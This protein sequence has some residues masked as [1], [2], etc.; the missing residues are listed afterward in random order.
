MVRHKCDNPLCCNPDHLELGTHADN[1]RDKAER[2]RA[3][4]GGQPPQQPRGAGNSNA[5]LTDDDVREIRRR[6]AEGGVTYRD[7]ATEFRVT[8]QN[9]GAIVRR[10]TWTHV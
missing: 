10:K 7:L 4:T 8:P 9:I 5:A 2:G 3:W 1:M 6:H